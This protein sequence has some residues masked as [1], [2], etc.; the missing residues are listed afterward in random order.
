MQS[1]TFTKFMVKIPMLEFSTN[2]DTRLTKKDVYSLP[3]IHTRV[4]QIVL[5]IIFLMSVVTIEH[6]QRTRIQNMQFTVYISDTPVT[7]KQSQGIKPRV[8]L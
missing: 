4:T 2:P 6:L 5:C 3:S 8:T 7:L 1:L